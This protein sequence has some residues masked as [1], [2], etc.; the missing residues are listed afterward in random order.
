MTNKSLLIPALALLVLAPPSRAAERN[1]SLDEAI[2]VA[3]RNR[4]DL[5]QAAIDLERADLNLLRAKLERVHLTIAGSGSE[6]I[7]KL[8]FQLSGPTVPD[9][10]ACFNGPCP[11]EQHNYGGT[12]DLTIPIWTGLTVEADI[13]RAR[14]LSRVA[15]AQARGTQRSVD[16]DVARAYWAVRRAELLRDVEAQALRRDQEIESIVKKRVDAGIAPQVD[17]NR[18]HGATLCEAI[19]LGVLRGN[20]EEGRAQLA[21]VLQ[22]EDDVA[23][24]EDPG[25]HAPVVPPLQLALDE[26]RGQRPELAASYA[27]VQAQGQAVRAARGGYWPQLQLFAH[28]D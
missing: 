13:E 16:L 9:N 14:W 20:V 22:I 26:A 12:A 2:A 10:A 1:L 4:S 21:A 19:Q 24:T 17:Y 5:Q 23:L 27:Q 15:Q 11:D 7:Q 25:A 6:R 18:V 28:A 8:Q 3:R